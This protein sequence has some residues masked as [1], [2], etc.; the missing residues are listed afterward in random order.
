[1]NDLEHELRRV[2]DGEVR[3]DKMT[4]LLYA[5]DAS[6]YQ[7]EP[8]GVVIPRHAGDVQAALEV[9]NRQNVPILP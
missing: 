3:F 1:M 6:M 9:A 7:V 8:I 2:V 4:R 5:T